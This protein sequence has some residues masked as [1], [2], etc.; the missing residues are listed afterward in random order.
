MIDN[1]LSI[2]GNLTNWLINHNVSPKMAPALRLLIVLAILF[3]ALFVVDFI[4]K[5]ILREGVKKIFL[6]TKNKWDDVLIDKRVFAKLAHLFPA[7]ILKWRDR[8]SV[9]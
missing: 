5:K 6:K 9:V 1:I 7:I 2:T 4:I 3:I 8:K